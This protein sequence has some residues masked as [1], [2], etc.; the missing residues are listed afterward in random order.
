ML[1]GTD[2]RGCRLQGAKLTL[3]CATFEGLKLDDD[4]V[5]MLLILIAKADIDA[6]WSVSLQELVEQIVGTDRSSAIA[7]IVRV[8]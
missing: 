6:R 8:R 7:R 2:L 5:A 4:Q 3:D 1:F